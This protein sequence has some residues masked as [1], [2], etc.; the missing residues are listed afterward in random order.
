MKRKEQGQGAKG[1]RGKGQP[2]PKRRQAEVIA[3]S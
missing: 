3:A 2:E 1:I